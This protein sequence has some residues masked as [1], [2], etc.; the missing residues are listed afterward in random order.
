MDLSEAIDALRARNEPVPLPLRLP[1]DKEITDAER[2][3]GL[4]F[5]ADYRRYLRDAS[6]VVFGTLEPCVVTPDAGYLDLVET[7]RAAWDLGVPRD[8]LPICQ[9]NGDYYC[10]AG[11][12][13]RFWS[14]DG[15]ADEGWPDLATWIME[16]WIG[17]AD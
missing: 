6:D 14:H 10:L 7:C 3:L 4:A 11:P 9:D 17:E 12:A 2:Q 5:P 1:T 8:W 15:A 16:V 13:V